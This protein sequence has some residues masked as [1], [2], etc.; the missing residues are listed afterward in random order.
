MKNS[1]VI[2]E[3]ILKSVNESDVLKSALYDLDLLPEQIDSMT[4]LTILRYF[5]SGYNLHKQE[6][7][8]CKKTME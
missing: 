6:C 1:I 8:N 7:E 4:R 5:V 3:N 2:P